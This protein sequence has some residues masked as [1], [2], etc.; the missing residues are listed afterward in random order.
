MWV[1]GEIEKPATIKV[2]LEF[3]M[4]LKASEDIITRYIAYM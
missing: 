1:L 3:G 2:Y 4:C